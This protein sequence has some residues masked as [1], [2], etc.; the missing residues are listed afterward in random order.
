MKHEREL[1][2]QLEAI[3]VIPRI[4]DIAEERGY[5]SLVILLRYMDIPYGVG[6]R[7]IEIMHLAEMIERSRRDDG[8]M[9]WVLS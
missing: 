6:A 7:A 2:L 5:F 9:V 8:S 3:E 4:V 1:G